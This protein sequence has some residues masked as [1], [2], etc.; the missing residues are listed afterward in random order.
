VPPT[1]LTNY[2][3]AV[4]IYIYFF[5]LATH[6]S[7]GSRFYDLTGVTPPLSPIYSRPKM[8]AP[9]DKTVRRAA[10]N[11]INLYRG[12]NK[13]ETTIW[14]SVASSASPT[15]FIQHPSDWRTTLLAEEKRVSVATPTTKSW[16][17]GRRRHRAWVWSASPTRGTHLGN[18]TTKIQKYATKNGS[19]G[20]PFVGL[21]TRWLMHDNTAK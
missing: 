21:K 18:G 6:F 8:P 3:S 2:S 13:A 5:Q 14:R 15:I 9:L 7:L 20:M 17:P 10:R 12:A 4:P 11:D 19:R 16:E 1:R